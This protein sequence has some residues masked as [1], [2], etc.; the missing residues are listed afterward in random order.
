MGGC[1]A[2]AKQYVEGLFSGIP[3]GAVPINFHR[4]AAVTTNFHEA[5]IYIE[6]TRTLVGLRYKLEEKSYGID[7]FRL[8]KFKARDLRLEGVLVVLQ[9]EEGNNQEVDK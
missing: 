8:L 6:T 2:K 3:G 7:L 1:L 4:G 9:A 5:K